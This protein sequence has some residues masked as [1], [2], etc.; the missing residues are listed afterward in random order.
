MSD[1]KESLSSSSARF[2]EYPLTHYTLSFVT[3][4]ATSVVVVVLHLGHTDH[5][6]PT[7]ATYF[8]SVM[9]L[10]GGNFMD[11]MYLTQAPI[12]VGGLI[13]GRGGL[14]DLLREMPSAIFNIPVIAFTLLLQRVYKEEVS[15]FMRENAEPITPEQAHEQSLVHFLLSFA[16][17]LSAGVLVAALHRGRTD[18]ISPTISTFFACGMY[19]RSGS[20]LDSIWL[21][22]VPPLVRGVIHGRGLVDLLRE[23]PS[24]V[25]SIPVIAITVLMQRLYKEVVTQSFLKH[26]QVIP[27]WV[28]AG[29]GYALGA[30]FFPEMLAYV[31]DGWKNESLLYMLP[32]Y[33]MVTFVFAIASVMI[34][35]GV[36]MGIVCAWMWW[37]WGQKKQVGAKEESECKSADNQ[38]RVD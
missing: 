36:V 5:I 32:V 28:C 34:C 6:T 24:A 12:L 1:Q 20:F 26:A 16:T 9:L 27:L 8:A 15:R 14:M 29:F 11:S 35:G 31:P 33:M 19:L 23:M 22:Q 38:G 37:P 7:I 17:A 10:R 4:L 2:L 21:M 25:F 18:H 3:A 30:S 13:R